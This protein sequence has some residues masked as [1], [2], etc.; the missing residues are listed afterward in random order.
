MDNFH[1]G[2]NL[3]IIRQAKGISQEVM[4]E[5]LGISQTTYSK[6]EKSAKIPSPGMVKKIAIILEEEPPL[7]LLGRKLEDL[8]PAPTFRLKAKEILDT[9]EGIFFYWILQ[10]PFVD[11]AY[12]MGEGFC[13]GLG[14]TDEVRVVVRFLTGF[15]AFIVSI[16]FFNRL[17]WG[18]DEVF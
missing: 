14:T 5:R 1:F 9:W 17:K 7:L 12:S 11:A 8:L 3:R 4:A 18:K 2:E 15:V 6:I 16:Y 10:I 13:Q